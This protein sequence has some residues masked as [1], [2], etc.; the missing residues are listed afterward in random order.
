MTRAREFGFS[1]AGVLLTA[2]I[3]AG[4]VAILMLVLQGRDLKERT[5]D[6]LS[7]IAHDNLLWHAASL[8]RDSLRLRAALWPLAADPT[9]AA[10]LD[11][12]SLRFDVLWS[13]TETARAGRLGV[14]IGGFDANDAVDRVAALLREAEPWLFAEGGPAPG[15]PARLIARLE[16]LD[17]ALRRLAQAAEQAEQ[18]R[19]VAL[20]AELHDQ[21][22]ADLH[23]ALVLVCVC[24]MFSVGAYADARR[25]LERSRE[26]RAN[27]ARTLEAAMSR[28]RFL[29]MVSHELR[30]PMNGVLGMAELLRTTPLTADQAIFVDHVAASAHGMNEVVEALLILSDIQDGACR[31]ESGAFDLDELRDTIA[32][33]LAPFDREETGHVAVIVEGE[34]VFGGD[35][36]RTAQ[37]AAFLA[38]YVRGSMAAPSCRCLIRLDDGL[39]IDIEIED[40]RR[41]AWEVEAIF[42]AAKPSVE[43]LSADALTPVAARELIG[44]MGG[45]C[46][47]RA[48]GPAARRIELSVPAIAAPAA[49]AVN[50]ALAAE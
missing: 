43:D 9:D 14:E 39:R 27:A 24:A 38:N 34:G 45:E 4:L 3:A 37:A 49:T 10:A 33:R 44:L 13:A 50:T 7:R 5:A 35:L 23:I 46:R 47:V 26:A 2:L 19:L 12:A 8:G 30:T 1:R 18:R 16:A 29:T 36:S 22:S 32:R 31:L 6:K 40:V 42:S 21:R 25:N 15:G 28:T 41:L 48:L 17:P 20:R 11:E